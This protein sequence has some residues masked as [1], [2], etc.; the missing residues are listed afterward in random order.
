IVETRGLRL[1]RK[2][3]GPDGP[4]LCQT[5]KREIDDEPQPTEERLIERA[6]HI[7]REDRQP[8]VRLHPLEQVVDLDVGVAIVAVL[9][10]AALPE[11]GV[12]LVE[13]QNRAAAVGRIE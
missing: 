9:D 2:G 3:A 6:L 12:R 10:L 4:S 7:G 11:Q 1:E 13:E 8:R 5:W